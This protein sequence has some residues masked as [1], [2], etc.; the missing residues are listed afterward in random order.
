MADD[1]DK[2]R[3]DYEELFGKKPFNGWDAAEL[4]KRID[5]KLS[6]AEEANAAKAD[7]PSADPYPT[8][9]DLD[10]MRAGT[11]RDRELKTR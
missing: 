4:Q 5:E 6:G 11:Y 1:L 8:Q 2:V 9:A 3:K 7:A 10:A